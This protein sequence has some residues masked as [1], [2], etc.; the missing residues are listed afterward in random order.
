MF[1]SLRWQEW[2]K[3]M[4]KSELAQHLNRSD[5]GAEL[6][7]PFSCVYVCVCVSFRYLS[8]Q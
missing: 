7:T 8:Y 2:S 3:A 5:L 4:G 6:S 1:M